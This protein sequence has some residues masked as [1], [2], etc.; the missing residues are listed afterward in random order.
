M[1]NRPIFDT[2]NTLAALREILVVC[3][4]DERG[5]ML[6]SVIE[7]QVFHHRR[8]RLVEITRRLVGKENLRLG[9]NC[10]SDR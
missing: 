4:D 3:D 5:T 1:I 2:N 7:E 9:S 10:P 8:G 6:L